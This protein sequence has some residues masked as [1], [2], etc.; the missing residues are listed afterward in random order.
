[1]VPTGPDNDAHAPAAVASAAT[2]ARPTSVPAPALAEDV[3]CVGCGYNLRGLDPSGRCPECGMSLHISIVRHRK[4]RR[5]PPPPDPAWAR[6]VA[7]GAVLSLVAFAL[8]V[9]LCLAPQWMFVMPYTLA[10]AG[11]TPGRAT[12]LCIGATAWVLAWY[13]AWKVT[14]RPRPLVN[15]QW[16]TAGSSEKQPLVFALGLHAYVAGQPFRLHALREA[17]QRC[18]SHRHADRVWFTR[19]GEIARHCH[20]ATSP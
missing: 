20:V 3:P 4:R 5:P 1:M 12:L 16:T 7:E 10:P 19:P 9:A 13:S 8:V 18:L 15:L 17:L 6:Q 2:A 11:K 14:R